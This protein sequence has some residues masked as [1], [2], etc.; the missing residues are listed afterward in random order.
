M[1][2]LLPFVQQRSGTY[3]KGLATAHFDGPKHQEFTGVGVK[4][5]VKL[6]RRPYFYW[7]PSEEQIT[8]YNASGHACL[9]QWWCDPL[10]KTCLAIIIVLID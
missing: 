6:G 3:T 1:W 8:C 7:T 2:S 10:D 4:I 5:G 9:R